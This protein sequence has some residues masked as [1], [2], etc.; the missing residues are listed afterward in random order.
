MFQN[1]N[2]NNYFKSRAD[3]TMALLD[4]LPTKRMVEDNWLIVAISKDAVP[5]A[6]M[7]S[8]KLNLDYDILLSESITAPN[9]L[10]CDVAKVSESEEIV[11]HEALIDSFEINLD[12]IYGQAHRVYEDK[13]V[14]RVY[15]YRKGELISSLKNRNV[16]FVDIGCET[17][18]SVIC[19]AKTAM[20][21]EAS[22]IMLATPIIAT[23]VANSLEIVVDELFSVREVDNFVN[24]DFYYEN[25]QKL[26]QDDI[27]EILKNSKGYLPFR[28]IGEI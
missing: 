16:L 6:N 14:P 24:I 7:I 2:F 9:N 22:S 21:L 17:G 27:I 11:I 25:L 20:K 3:A 13:I 15:K 28:K 4:I 19:C 12:Y 18:L 23:D 8:L 10:E 1:L 5:I 26:E